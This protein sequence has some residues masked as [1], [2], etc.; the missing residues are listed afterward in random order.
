MLRV[1][2]NRSHLN[3]DK[4][5]PGDRPRGSLVPAWQEVKKL[6]VRIPAR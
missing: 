3:A 5:V 4:G 2:A 6:R 1:R